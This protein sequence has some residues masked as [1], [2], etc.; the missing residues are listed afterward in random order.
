MAKKRRNSAGGLIFD[1]LMRGVFI[2]LGV[3]AIVLT[4]YH[5]TW[6]WIDG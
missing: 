2:G 1:L 5:W 6:G 4:H 3:L